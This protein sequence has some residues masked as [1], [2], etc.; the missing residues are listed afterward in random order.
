MGLPNRVPEF[1]DLPTPDPVKAMV[2]L[3]SA[4]WTNAELASFFGMSPDQF[5]DMLNRVEGLRDT[6]DEARDEPNRKVEGALFRKALGFRSKEITKEDGKPVKVV[7]KEVSPDAVACIF[8]L[9]NR[10]PKRWRDVIEHSFSLRD[11]MDRAYTELRT[12]KQKV[13]VETN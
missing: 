6:L 11:R 1:I 4:G 8:W 7:I 2:A 13:I 5:K 9:K 3:A 10:E 12:D